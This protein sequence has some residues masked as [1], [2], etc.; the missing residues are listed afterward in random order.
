MKPEKKMKMNCPNCHTQ[1]NVDDL[2]VSQFE[3]S[4]RLDMQFEMK[5][6]EEELN[7]RK[8]EFSRATAALRKEKEDVEQIVATKVKAQ[9]VQ[10]EVAIRN[11]IRQ[12]ISDERSEELANLHEE[13][14]LKSEQLKE[15]HGTKAALERFRRETQERES[16]IILQKEQELTQR[17]EEARLS[18]SE[19]VRQENFLKIKEREKVI[20]DLKNKLDDARR[21]AEQG[22]MQ[23]QGE[24]QE[25]EIIEM[26]RE[27][28]PS[29]EIKQSKKGSN[30]ADILHVVRVNG[31]ECGKIYYESKRT[32]TWSND[33]IPKFK[34]DNLETKAD[35]L[36]LVTNALPKGI[37]RYGLIDNVWVCSFNDVR[38]LSL[39]LRYGLIKLQQVAIAN[40][41][42]DV[43]I[44]MLYSY[45][46]SE[47]FKNLFESILTGF[48]ALQDSHN[49][50]KLKLQR[51]W[52]EREKALEQVLR[53]TVEFYGTLK[54]IGGA[55]IR[56]IPLLEMQ[57]Q[58]PKAG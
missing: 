15:L 43:K 57:N 30:A 26:L 48:K 12:E 53:N 50:E 36:V 8:E 28:H 52:K 58:L 11:A 20:E 34:Q 2:L 1:I 19:Q 7:A 22:S 4:I 17:L 56:E 6:R 29:D 31:T 14:K 42:K 23:L 51:L 39:V 41:G 37:E 44:E 24:I 38:E 13:M 3:E 9:M 33:W 10:R 47:D 21:K 40:V 18:I 32:K 5:K 27:F 49:N 16:A 25:L 45:L 54:G 35:I 55:S 46:C